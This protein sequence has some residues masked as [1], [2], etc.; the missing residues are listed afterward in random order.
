MPGTFQQTRS[1]RIIRPPAQP[2]S[3]GL[4]QALSA[5]IESG[6]GNI[7]AL[8]KGLSNGSV[9]NL[10]GSSGHNTND[11]MID[12]A[13]TSFNNLNAVPSTSAAVDLGDGSW[14]NQTLAN[15]VNQSVREESLTSDGG[16]ELMENE[17]PAWPL[18]PG[19]RGGR[20]NMPKD[21]MLA[22]RRARNRVAAVES[23][24]RKKNHME[25]LEGKVKE[26]EFA[27]QLLQL[28]CKNLEQ[29]WV[30]V[31]AQLRGRC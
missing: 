14:D 3:Y 28:H 1:G 18:P 8:L 23:R 9:N 26:R 13:L 22:R 19:G 7:D 29:Q 21:E 11:P 17:L 12:P 6:S 16:M 2:P 20:K 5:E 24:R 10:N 27:Y 30:L 25:G 15:A 31:S 4:L